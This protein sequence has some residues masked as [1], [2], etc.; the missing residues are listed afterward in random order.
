MPNNISV[1]VE[2]L[3]D[4][5]VKFQQ[6]NLAMTYEARR[7]T[8][9]S[10]MRIETRAKELAHEQGVHD[11]GYLIRMIKGRLY[12]DGMTGEVTGGADYHVY[13]ELGTRRMPARPMLYP[14][15]LEEKPI[16]L[17]RLEKALERAARF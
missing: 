10:T 16:Y 7:I 14:A 4:L 5:R 15:A 1:S 13:H 6:M 3:G 12:D 11:T 9:N 2:G 8:R 17:K